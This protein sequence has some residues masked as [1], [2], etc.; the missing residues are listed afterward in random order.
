MQGNINTW[1][2][3]RGCQWDGKN[4][5]IAQAEAVP[6]KMDEPSLLQLP[7]GCF[8][9]EVP[10]QD[11]LPWRGFPGDC[12]CPWKGAHPSGSQG[13]QQLQLCSCR[14][15]TAMDLFL[16]SLAFCPDRHSQEGIQPR[17][18]CQTTQ[19]GETRVKICFKELL[20]S[21]ALQGLAL[22]RCV[23]ITSIPPFKLFRI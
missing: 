11:P 22:P 19:P 9:M 1:I 14:P 2:R 20:G 5:R 23:V 17:W 6:R 13:E 7:A 16:F 10:E 4:P 18:I 15:Q 12:S 8:W 21:S 3:S